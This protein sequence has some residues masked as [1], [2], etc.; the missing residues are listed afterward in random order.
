M[1]KTEALTLKQGN[2]CAIVF[3]FFSNAFTL[4]EI[5]AEISDG[6]SVH[7]HFLLKNKNNYFCI[8]DTKKGN[9]CSFFFVFFSTPKE[10]AAEISD[11]GSVHWHFLWFL[12]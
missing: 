5:A 9:E 2:E 1:H 8:S 7:W 11:G 12:P 4:K 6:G 10:I 3:L